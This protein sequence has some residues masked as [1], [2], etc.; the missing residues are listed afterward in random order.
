MKTH[1]FIT[2]HRNA[3]MN[4]DM[5]MNKVDAPK[6]VYEARLCSFCGESRRRRK[7]TEHFVSQS[8]IMYNSSLEYAAYKSEP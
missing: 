6:M 4:M 7:A 3:T 1:G 2:S 5:I 8:V